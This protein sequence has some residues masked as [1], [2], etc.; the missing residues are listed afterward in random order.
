M[1]DTRVEGRAQIVAFD[2]SLS[3]P[4]LSAMVGQLASSLALFR[5]DESTSVHDD[6]TL[7][8]IVADDTLMFGTELV[9][10]QRYRGKTNERLTRMMLN[11]GLATAGIA[12]WDP[13]GVVLDPMCG[14]GTTLH[15]ALAY[16]LDAVGFEPDRS[17]LDHQA[18]FLRTWAKRQRL[19]HEAMAHKEKNKEL[20][21]TSLSVASNREDLKAGTGQLVSTFCADG[22]DQS[23][24]LKA[25]MVDVVVADLPYGVQHNKKAAGKGTGKN[26]GKR[27]G[28]KRAAEAAP[29]SPSASVGSSESVELLQRLVPAWARWLRPGGAMCLAWNLKRAKRDAV[30]EILQS[31][32]F[33]PVETEWTGKTAHRVDSTILRDVIV[34]ELLPENLRD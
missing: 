12:P 15:W 27:S 6:V 13:I 33:S 16:G 34:A 31:N 23:I 9:T 1:V 5:V 11:M 26:A 25:N 21:H 30:K 28:K 3:D 8:P 24:P 17:S 14:R 2:S 32:G 19:P 4:E 22:A 18:N 29:E 10:T 20:R 7:R